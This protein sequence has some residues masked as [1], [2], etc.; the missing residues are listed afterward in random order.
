MLCKVLNGH[1]PPP[2]PIGSRLHRPKAG[3]TILHRDSG[4]A[5][6]QVAYLRNDAF[7]CARLRHNGCF[8]LEGV[9][10]LRDGYTFSIS[11][12]D[13][14]HYVAGPTY[15]DKCRVRLHCYNFLGAD[16]FATLRE[17]GDG[18]AVPSVTR[19]H[20]VAFRGSSRPHPSMLAPYASRELYS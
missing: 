19:C 7:P 1:P 2:A 9:E 18:N 16:K 20:H 11:L 3:R 10:C 4:R 15:R 17:R 14:R 6:T 5:A 8:T 13:G 12:I